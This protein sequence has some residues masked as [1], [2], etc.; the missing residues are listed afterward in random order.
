[1]SEPRIPIPRQPEQRFTVLHNPT[2]PACRKRGARGH[3]YGFHWR[4]SGPNEFVMTFCSSSR[5][6][7]PGGAGG[8]DAL[9]T[10]QFLGVLR[11]N[12]SRYEAS[13]RAP[14]MPKR[15]RPRSPPTAGGL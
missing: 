3:G 6:R 13:S 4:F 12:L 15:R 10:E 5:G 7:R 9:V 14:A 8:D 2:V 1:M 11:E